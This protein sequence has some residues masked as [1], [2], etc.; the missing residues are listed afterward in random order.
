MKSLMLAAAAALSLSAQAPEKPLVS[1][2]KAMFLQTKDVITRS[3]EK[4]PDEH[5]AFKPTPEVR[6]FA[7]I[8]GHIA[9]AQHSICSAATGTRKAPPGVEKSKSG[10]AEIV[11]ALKE[12]FAYCEEVIDG[13]TE[14]QAVEMMNFFGG[15]RTRISEIDF[16]TA[17][18]YEHY[19]NLVTYMRL[20]GIVP[21]SSEPRR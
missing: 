7:Q 18:N 3:A 8:L 5:Y 15:Q 6:S 20:K 9:D 4:M 11:P 19:G 1:S 21:P 16:N 2:A 13:M 12:A 10:K 17:H 14:A